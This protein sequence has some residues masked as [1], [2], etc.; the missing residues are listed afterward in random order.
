[1]NDSEELRRSA[2]HTIQSMSADL[3]ILTR[4]LS[5]IGSTVQP[6]AADADHLVKLSAELRETLAAIEA[7]EGNEQ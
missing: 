6:Q 2:L 4:R 5:R 7:A 3:T 1:M